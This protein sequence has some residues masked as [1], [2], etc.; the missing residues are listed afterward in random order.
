MRKPKAVILSDIHYNINSWPL[1]DTALMA[2]IA[3]AEAYN[4]PVVIAGD[5][6]DTKANLRGECIKAMI[7]TISRAKV[8]V[9]ILVGNHDKIN[10]KSEEHSLEFLR[11]YAHIIDKPI[12]IAELD[13]WILPYQHDVET[14]KARVGEIQMGST[15]IMHQGV[16]EAWTGDYVFDKTAVP[17]EWLYHLNVISGHYHRY[18]T[19]QNVTYCGSPYT[20][21][22]GEATDGPKGFLVLFDDGTHEQKPLNLRKHVVIEANTG[23]LSW[24]PPTVN[25]GDLVWLK[26]TGRA[27]T[28]A[29]FSKDSFKS[30]Y[31]DNYKL[32]K[33]PTDSEEVEIKADTMTAQ[34]VLDT[35]IEKVDEPE[36]F[37]AYLKALWREIL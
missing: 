29:K 36:E 3:Q 15:L 34:E 13:V 31:G 1:A 6:H 10:E 11:P 25:P 8:K 35:L 4:V 30:V 23:N 5:L 19:V 32:D 37:K 7:G 16:K 14:F 33:I 9:F 2:A 18:Q 12:H 24:V 22:F 26:L 21:S 20:Q 27:S 17:V 28:L